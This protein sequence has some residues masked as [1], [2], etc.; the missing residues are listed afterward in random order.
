MERIQIESDTR[1]SLVFQPKEHTLITGV[2]LR[3]SPELKQRLKSAKL[4]KEGVIIQ[5]T[6]DEIEELAIVLVQEAHRCRNKQKQKKLNDIIEKLY[7]L[8]DKYTDEGEWEEENLFEEFLHSHFPPEIVQ[9]IQSSIQ[10]KSIGGIDELNMAIAEIMEDYNR[11]SQNDMGGLSPEQVHRLIYC[12]WDDE[13]NGVIQ[14]NSKLTVGDLEQ[15]QHFINTRAILSALAE[16]T[17]VQSTSAGNLN[18]EFVKEMIKSCMFPEK[19]LDDLYRFNKVINEHDVQPLH[20]VRVLCEIAG[21]IKQEKNYFTISRKGEDLLPND[22]AGELFLLLFKTIFK[23][24][25]LA[26]LDGMPENQALQ[27]TITYSLYQAQ[28]YFE[29]WRLDDEAVSCIL[30]PAAYEEALSQGY[31][32]HP[33]FQSYT[34]IIRPLTDLGLLQSRPMVPNP[35]RY[36]IFEFKNAPLFHKFIRFHL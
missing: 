3:I 35:K 28:Q 34:R 10:N 17:K 5:L 6:L 36:P 13:K 26:Y 32:D 7:D 23:R 15:S 12:D 11:Q 24:F 8:M 29:V 21:F 27:H 20:I 19:F 14:F 2:S 9:R 22:K 1:I 16:K 31:K 18:R 25:N 4:E 33:G 30:L